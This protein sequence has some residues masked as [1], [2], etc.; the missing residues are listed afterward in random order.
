MNETKDMKALAKSLQANVS[1]LGYT[2][3]GEPSGA[4]LMSLGHAY[5]VLAKM[6]GMNGWKALLACR[7]QVAS[8]VKVWVGTWYNRKYGDIESITYYLHQDEALKAAEDINIWGR[9]QAIVEV[10]VTDGVLQNLKVT[11]GD[12]I[13]F[14]VDLREFA[15]SI[16]NECDSEYSALL[17]GN[18]DAKLKALLETK[19]SGQPATQPAEDD[20]ELFSA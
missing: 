2:L 8:P 12:Q 4:S 14:D 18:D 15:A 19:I 7:K 5:H 16:A 13:Y 20:Q 6:A 11:D 9:A 1:E 17:A 10:E 3:P